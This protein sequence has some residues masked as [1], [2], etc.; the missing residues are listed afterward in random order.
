MEFDHNFV[1]INLNPMDD[2]TIMQHMNEKLMQL[3]VTTYKQLFQD[4]MKKYNTFC[5]EYIINTIFYQFYNYWKESQTCWNPK[6]LKKK[7]RPDWNDQRLKKVLLRSQLSI[8]KDADNE[9]F[10]TWRKWNKLANNEKKYVSRMFWK[11]K[12]C[13]VARYC[14][15]KCQKQGWNIYKHKFECNIIVCFQY[16]LTGSDC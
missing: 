1:R 2:L 11:C 7:F 5:K 8:G 9:S 14:C 16:D 3:D 10:K 6:C 13:R 4:T 15:K 12:K